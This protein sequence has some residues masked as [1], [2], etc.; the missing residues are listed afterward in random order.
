M[1]T[2]T[3]NKK[4]KVE[5]PKEDQS[6]G[7]M[8]YQVVEFVISYFGTEIVTEH[9]TKI[10]KDGRQTVIGGCGFIPHGYAV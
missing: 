9:D 7:V 6:K 2:I 4:A 8:S 10:E 3:M 5:A 1:K